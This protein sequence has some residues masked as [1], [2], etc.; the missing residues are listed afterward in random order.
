MRE[1]KTNSLIIK[2]IL[3]ILLIVGFFYRIYGLNYN[4]SFWT[5]ENHVAIFVRAIL[6]RGK[7]VLT[8]GYST[9]IYQWLLYWMGAISA[10]IF[11]LNE[12]AVRFPSVIFGVLT[13]WAIYLVGKEL[14]NRN[15]GLVAATLITFLKIEILWSRQAR[16]YQA[17]QFFYL[18][19]AY[20]LYRLFKFEKFNLKY[21]LGFLTCVILASLMHGLGMLIFVVGFIY[22]LFN[23]PSFFK[24]KWVFFLSFISLLFLIVPFREIIYATL[25]KL[26]KTNNLTYYR[27]FLWHNYSLLT[28]LAFAGFLFLIL[29]RKDNWGLPF[30][31]LFVQTLVVSFF[32]TNYTR[33]FYIVFPFLVLTAS[34]TLHEISRV[35]GKK[36]SLVTLILVVFIIIMGYQSVFLPKKIYSLNDDMQ[37]TPEV[38]WKKIY[39][40]VG[41]KISENNDLI[42]I[43]NWNDLSVWYLGEGKLNY[44]LTE[45]S[46]Q[47]KD[48]LSGALIINGTNDL[49][50]VIKEKKKGLIIID[51]WDKYLSNET[52]LYCRNNLKKELEVDRLYPI[53]P[54]Y[55]P[56]EVYSWGI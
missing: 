41:E 25:L 24:N 35:V 56:V 14:F 6:E 10:K 49:K 40:F 51:S 7:P 47:K 32:L 43:A 18:L 17:L 37:E 27:V 42:L 4:H 31:F 30:L 55:W 28:F 16:P 33:Y 52:R 9:G 53:Q 20:C 23:R 54:R 13:I 5:D 29:T 8:N 1:S 15:V 2:L 44:L 19:S 48:G 46:S 45:S 26:G 39:G 3:I 11:G 38:D 34:F 12:F 21:F 36:H 50:N 22:F